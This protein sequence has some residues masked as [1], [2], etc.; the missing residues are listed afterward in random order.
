[1]QVTRRCVA[2]PHVFYFFFLWLN[3]GHTSRV[4]FSCPRPSV[5]ET[6]HQD[7]H[8][9]YAHNNSRDSSR[10]VCSGH[11][12]NRD[13]TIMQDQYVRPYSIRTYTRYDIPYQRHVLDHPDTRDSKV[14]QTKRLVGVA[15]STSRRRKSGGMDLGESR[16]GFEIVTRWRCACLM[17]T[18]ELPPLEHPSSR[19]RVRGMIGFVV[20]DG[21]C[22]IIE[23]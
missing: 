6:D 15:S 23:E 21:V 16:W 2:N 22:D 14:G 12:S 1:M 3:K 11:V 13:G 4:A 19:R 7:A 5:R 10:A 18:A 8:Q 20:I 9:G 17:M